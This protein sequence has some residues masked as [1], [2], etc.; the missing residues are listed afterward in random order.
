MKL[1]HISIVQDFPQPVAKIFNWLGDH[2]NLGAI[3]FPFKVERIRD[4]QDYLNGVG[5]VRRL[6][7]FPL[8]PVEEMVTVYIPDEHIEYTITSAMSP[9]SDHLGVMRFEPHEGGTR[10]HYTIVF[11]GALPLI[12]PVLKVGLAQGIRR[13]L[14]KLARMSI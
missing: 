9:I 7:S 1:Q 8:P 3:F 14:K 6:S 12:G 5:S 10:L 13:G 4:G 11:R 2:N